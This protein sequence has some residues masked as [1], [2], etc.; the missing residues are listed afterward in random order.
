M[1]AVLAGKIEALKDREL[2]DYL[3]GAVETL[4]TRKQGKAADRIVDR[5]GA[6]LLDPD[7]E[8]RTLA[9]QTLTD[10]IKRCG[11]EQRGALIRRSA[12][13]MLE[14]VRFET[15][16]NPA[17][18]EI[19]V[20]L[21][22]LAQSLIR[23]GRLEVC[24]PI[25]ESLNFACFPK[26]SPEDVCRLSGRNLLK[27]MASDEVMAALME[28][29]RSEDGPK[30]ELSTHILTQLGPAAME[31]LLDLLKNSQSRH[32][33]ARILKVISVIGPPALSYLEEHIKLGSPWYYM[34]NLIL[35]FGR[36]GNA[37]HVDIL[38]PFLS[39]KDIRVRREC[40]NS[41][42]MIGGSRREEI[43][44][45]ALARSDDRIKIDIV[46]MLGRIESRKSVPEL[47][48]ILESKPLILTKAREMLEENVRDTLE[49]IA[50]P[51][52][53]AALRSGKPRKT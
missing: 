17:Y 16:N 28:P 2:M 18:E 1:N 36:T 45:E 48:K 24:R 3:P 5:L 26:D 38:L 33:R 41:L 27:E 34:R 8:I 52:A 32:E 20:Y 6:R 25:L 11:S 37:G 29:F 10:I 9:S 50:T 21:M 43:F 53:L 40:L 46:K 39:D 44:L 22:E 30:R 23:Q 42:F 12:K 4:Y 7:K 35:L 15:E 31:P 13:K 51:E 19:C 47:A 49:R 14:W